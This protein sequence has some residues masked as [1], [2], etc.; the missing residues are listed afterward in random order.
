MGS[1][2]RR[3]VVGR[4]ARRR[5]VCTIKLDHLAHFAKRPIISAG[6]GI[7]ICVSAGV[8]VE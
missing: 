2:E 8:H 5:F 7:A 4:H 3:V 1:Q 6:F